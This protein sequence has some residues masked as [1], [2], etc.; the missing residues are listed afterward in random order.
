MFVHGDELP[1][2]SS[3]AFDRFVQTGR[4]AGNVRYHRRE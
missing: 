3:R 1:C 2:P 4:Q